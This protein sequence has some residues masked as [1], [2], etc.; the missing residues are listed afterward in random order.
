MNKY[1]CSKCKTESI[2]YSAAKELN[3]NCPVCKEATKHVC[4][5]PLGVS[6]NVILKPTSPEPVAVKQVFGEQKPQ[7]TA[8]NVPATGVAPKPTTPVAK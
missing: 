2:I 4:E 7:Q 3:V 8:L 6:P 1:T 5:K